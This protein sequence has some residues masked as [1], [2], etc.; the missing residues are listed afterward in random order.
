[1]IVKSNSVPNFLYETPQKKQYIFRL[2]N[3]NIPKI[4]PY[5]EFL[6]SNPRATKTQRREAIKSFYDML[7]DNSS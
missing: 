7:L 5:S 1:M 2:S 4:I 3:Y 6:K